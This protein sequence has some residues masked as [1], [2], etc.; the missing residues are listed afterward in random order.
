MTPHHLAKN[1]SG[2]PLL[3]SIHGIKEIP[4]PLG[5][6][7]Q[8]RRGRIFAEDMTRKFMSEYL[9]VLTKRTKWFKD[10]SPIKTGDLVLV[11]DPNLTRKAWERARVL[12]I[13]HGRDDIGRV[14]DLLF[15]DGSIKKNRSVKRLAKIDIKRI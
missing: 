11:I 14:V 13:Y 15:P 7:D 5:D 12:K 6:R 8:Y 1:K 9:P 4:D 10:C 2:W 3:P